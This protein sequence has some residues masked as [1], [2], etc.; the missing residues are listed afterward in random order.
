MDLRLDFE[1]DSAFVLPIL[2]LIGNLSHSAI[3]YKRDDLGWIS[4]A[5]S[6][7]DVDNIPKNVDI[8][9]INYKFYKSL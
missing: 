8:I 4:F 5:W 2:L 3:N 9:S 6:L 1:F 7:L